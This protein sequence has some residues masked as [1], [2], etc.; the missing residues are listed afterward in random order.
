MVVPHVVMVWH[1][2]IPCKYECHVCVGGFIL[3]ERVHD[4]PIPTRVLHTCCRTLWYRYD[5]SSKQMARA[6]ESVVDDG[7]Y[8]DINTAE[9]GGGYMDV[10]PEHEDGF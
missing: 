6:K 10:E 9:E 3:Y 5:D 1:S 2:T 8:M 4:N 7:E